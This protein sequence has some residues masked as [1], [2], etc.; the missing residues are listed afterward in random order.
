MF[1]QPRDALIETRVSNEKQ[2]KRTRQRDDSIRIRVQAS[3]QLVHVNYELRS[4][5]DYVR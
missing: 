2:P 1:S 4:Q 5:N 3:M